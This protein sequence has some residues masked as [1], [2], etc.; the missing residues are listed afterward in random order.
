[1]AK[2]P[3]QKRPPEPPIPKSGLARLAKRLGLIWQRLG[4]P[5]L[6]KLQGGLKAVK[7]S[8]PLQT[9][10]SQF[11]TI[12]T[13]PKAQKL[14]TTL[15]PTLQAVQA[16]W[17]TVVTSPVV[18]HFPLR[19]REWRQLSRLHKGFVIASGGGLV[20]I[21]GW[22]WLEL[23]LPSI[24]PVLTYTRPGTISIASIDGVILQQVGPAT[25]QKLKIKQIPKPLI[26]AFIAS[27]DRRFYQHNGVDYQGI[28]RAVG[29]NLRSLDVVEGGSTITQQ[30]ARQVFLSQ[31]RSA[32]RKLRE[33][34]LAQ[35]IDRELDK[36]QIL[37]AYLNMVYLGSGAYG[38][39]DAAWVYFGKTVD[40]LKLPELALLV[41]ITPAPSS[42]SPLEN[43]QLALKRR[44]I[45]LKRMQEEGFI[46]ATAADQALQAPLGLNPKLPKNLR[47]EAPYFTAYILKQLP[48]YVP[49]SVIE[50]GGLTIE[51]TLNAKWQQLADRAIREAVELDGPAEGFTQGAMVAIDPKNGAIK[52]MVG[53]YDFNKSQFNRVTQAQRQPG[54]TFKTFL[55]T[56]AIASGLSPYQGYLDAPII[57][58]GYQ[59]ENYTR[60]YGGWMSMRDALTQ[61]INV[62]AV[63]TLLDVGFDPVVQMAKNMGIQSPLKRTYSLS[64]GAFEVNL[65]ELTSAHGTLAAQGKQVKPYGISRILGPDGQL[66]YRTKPRPKQVVDKNTAAIMS[67]MLQDVVDYGTG[68]PARINRAAAGK[69][70]TS[71][72]ARD[73]WFVGYVPQ[74][75][76]GVWLGNDND[77]PTN[78][79]SGTAAYAWNRFMSFVTQSLPVEP[80]PKLPQ[81][82]GR[83]GSI[84]AKP[85]KPKQVSE[86]P[87]P[88]LAN[89]EQGD[90]YYPDQD[91]GGY[92]QEP[93]QDQGSGG[94]YQ[95]PYQDQG[96]GGYYQEPYPDQ[97]SSGYSEPSYSSGDAA[98]APA[99]PEPAAPAEPPPPEPVPEA[100]DVPQ[101]EAPVDTAPPAPAPP[102]VVE[103]PPPEPAPVEPPAEPATAEE[104]GIPI[105]RSGRNC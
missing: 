86:P 99:A 60:R 80:F 79:A 62:V 20:V 7:S 64:L 6:H 104:P 89:P 39:A 66:F 52:A 50:A 67:W 78:G 27:E 95:E 51:T 76:A 11:N 46:T 93:Y 83:K 65:L 13:H 33:I 36:Q 9:L 40:Q 22:T 30:L 18:Q 61:S 101:P 34:L 16:G 23:T 55:Y 87:P 74:L 12:T 100:I 17:H 31:E 84:K 82:E 54:S 8:S 102:P 75:V 41:G 71:E 15:A 56:T 90:G 44:N 35:K 94:Y 28:L 25:Y 97:G 38:V 3:L 48:N 88:Q 2:F 63:K 14:Q 85:I 92:Y 19:P 32:W 69:T 26:Q 10:Q 70:G 73:L 53:G 72:K 91:S 105:C 57:L 103:A 1:V 43:P 98:P 29:A 45:V 96:S 21:G 42:Y 58:D 37:E 68:Q 4:S 49:K 59:P 47:K 24:K 5:A 81:L 77:Q